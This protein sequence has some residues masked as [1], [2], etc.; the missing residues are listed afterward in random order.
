MEIQNCYCCSTSPF[1][2]CCKPYIYG[3]LKVPNPEKL[4]RSRFSAYATQAI[5]YLITTTHPTTR[6]NYK[7]SDILDWSKNN[8]WVKLEIIDTTATTV[9]FKAYFFDH[10]FNLQMHHEK[11]TF[12]LDNDIWFYVDGIFY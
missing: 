10:D 9:E 5:N 12:I 6:K 11:S 2:N 3:N 7:K 8:K 4:M 1:E